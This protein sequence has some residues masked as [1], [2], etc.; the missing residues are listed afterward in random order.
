MD[1][2]ENE[3]VCDT[4]KSVGFYDKIPTIG[5][6]SAKT[7]DVVEFFPRVSQK[8]QNLHL[9][10]T[11]NVEDFYGEI[12]YDL[13]GQ[14]IE[15]VITTSNMIDIYTRLEILLERKL[16]GHADTLLEAS[17]LTVEIYKRGEVQREW[18]YPNASKEFNTI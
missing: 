5:L 9:P 8:F 7:Q 1:N 14:G 17:N 10:T 13:E 4:L 16:F 6:K 15:K 3:T 11:G 18:H 2:I 12:F